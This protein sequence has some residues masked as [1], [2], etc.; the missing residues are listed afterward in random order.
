MGKNLLLEEKHDARQK[1]RGEQER[2][3]NDWPRKENE[4]SHL[5]S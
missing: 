3:E 5:G 2:E 4:G 1:E